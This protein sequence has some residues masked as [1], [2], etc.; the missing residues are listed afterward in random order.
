[1]TTEDLPLRSLL[2]SAPDGFI[3]VNSEGRI[4]WANI[5]AH[6]L[7]RYPEGELTGKLVEEL[8]PERFRT[9]HFVYRRDYLSNSRVRPMGLG[10]SLVGRRSDATEF[11][12]EISLSPL[13]TA[14]GTLVTAVVRDVT[15]RK[16]MEE[17]RTVLSMQ[18]ETERERDRIAMDLHDGIMQDIYAAALTMELAISEVE[19]ERF[20]DAPGVER[21]I[22]HLHGVVRNIRSY[23]FDLRPREFAGSLPEALSNLIEEFG[24]NSQ[25][26][27]SANISEEG[28]VDLPTSVA[29]YHIAHEALSN[30]QR[31]ARASHVD[32]HLSFTD[33]TGKLEVIDNGASF[34]P[35]QAAP[36][37]HHGL[38]NM[39]SRA[40]AIH[41][42]LDVRSAPGKGTTLSITF[43]TARAD[44]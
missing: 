19:D 18:L 42:T 38:R 1:V 15:D 43:P 32:L 2:D 5:T 41:A 30:V 26:E 3:V 16:C 17:E 29:L 10:L 44:V 27:S 25:I 20:A 6:T 24:Q 4:A 28:R 12:V 21:S 34:D 11:P 14:S 39:A 40:H 23:I 33:A 35:S 13:E 37:N 22:D 36:D 7:F 8:V 31:H 9:G